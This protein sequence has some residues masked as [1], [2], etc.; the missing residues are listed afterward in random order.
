MRG[1]FLW[2]CVCG[3]GPKPRT[4]SCQSFPISKVREHEV[5][6]QGIGV[7]GLLLGPK[8]RTS[9]PLLLSPFAIVLVQQDLSQTNALWGYLYVFIWANVFHGFFQAEFNRGG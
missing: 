2:F 8:P 9:G 3:L 1:F 6:L 5:P 4:S 7:C